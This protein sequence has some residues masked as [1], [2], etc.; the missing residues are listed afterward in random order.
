M[1]GQAG[2]QR[3]GH[4]LEPEAPGQ[5]PPR[6]EPVQR[7]RD[8]CAGDDDVHHGH[9]QHGEAGRGGTVVL[10]VLQVQRQQCE[11]GDVGGAHQRVDQSRSAHLANGE[12]PQ[13]H[14]RPAA[15]GF[16]RHEAGQQ[17]ETRHQQS[18]REGARRGVAERADGVPD[19]QQRGGAGDRPRHVE[20]ADGTDRE[21]RIRR[22][23]AD[24]GQR[25]HAHRQVDQ[26]YRRPAE[27]I[28]EWP[29]DRGADRGA[30]R[31]HRAPHPEGAMSRGGAGERRGQ[32]RQLGGD[33]HGRAET[34]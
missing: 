8:Q 22:E 26:E 34:L 1:L 23:H 9:R 6:A 21:R 28:G 14:Q 15:A 7:V 29:T 31:P 11:G 16:E 13:R 3:H 30:R 33:H 19:D 4:R 32:Q 10:G 27:Q 18:R 12:Q 20:P 2:E 25:R 24:E 5:H 17:R